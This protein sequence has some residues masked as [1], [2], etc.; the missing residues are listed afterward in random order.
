MERSVAALTIMVV[1]MAGV[2]S[3][4]LFI[5][6]GDPEGHFTITLDLKGLDP[7]MVTEV[8]SFMYED[9]GL[10]T[11]QP[12]QKN[13]YDYIPGIWAVS[14]LFDTNTYFVVGDAAYTTDVLGAT[15]ISYALAF[16]GSLENPEGRTDSL[17]TRRERDQGNLI[18]VGGPAVNPTATEFGGYFGISYRHRPQESFSIS[19]ERKSIYLDLA[20]Y[21][22]EDICIVYIGQF[23]TR[24]VM[25]VWG[26]EWQGT[27]AGSMFM[28]DPLNW[29]QYKNAHLLLLRWKDYNRDGLV[30]MSEITVEQFA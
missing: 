26:Y 4:A 24:N 17:L 3:A 28:A 25:L 18:I 20:Q 13:D 29:E 30:Q 11:I 21:P 2:N 9:S 1:M 15:K 16:G 12:V 27:Y 10:D 22:Y 23:D 7:D 14:S 19:C 5:S 6:I 8:S